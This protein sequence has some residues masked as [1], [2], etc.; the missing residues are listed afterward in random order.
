MARKENQ[1][2]PNPFAEG[3]DS[4]EA[5][6]AAEASAAEEAGEGGEGSEEGVTSESEGFSE[7]SQ[8]DLLRAARDID[9]RIRERRV[10]DALASLDL[11][12]RRRKQ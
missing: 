4:A 5:K 1:S 3:E 12:R 7:K 11:S 6:A 9:E 10:E 2:T 8:S